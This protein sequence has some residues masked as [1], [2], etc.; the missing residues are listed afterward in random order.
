MAR[1]HDLDELPGPLAFVLA[2][3][4]VQLRAGDDA[5]AWPTSKGRVVVLVTLAS[6]ANGAPSVEFSRR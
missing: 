6:G 1:V 3:E 4:V 5:P 2:S